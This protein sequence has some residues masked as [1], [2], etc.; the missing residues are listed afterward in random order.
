MINWHDVTKTHLETFDLLINEKSAIRKL[1]HYI[2]NLESIER[3]IRFSNSNVN[4]TSQPSW[5]I[6]INK[7]WNRIS[8]IVL[9]SCIEGL[10]HFWVFTDVTSCPI[11]KKKKKF[12]EKNHIH[13]AKLIQL[14]YTC[15]HLR[16][17]CFRY[18]QLFRILLGQEA[19]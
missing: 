13:T 1:E 7:V 19:Y 2:N 16:K 14:W 18:D 9:N 10:L 17:A 4:V 5:Q 3:S 6:E 15:Q 11:K 8:G 12:K